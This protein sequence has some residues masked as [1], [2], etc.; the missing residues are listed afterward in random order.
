MTIIEEGCALPEQPALAPDGTE[1][2]YVL[3]TTDR[4]ADQDVRA[5]WRVSGGKARQLT[6]GKS[7][8]APAWSPGGS[9]LAFLRSTEDRPQIWLLDGGEPEQVTSLPHGAGQPVWSPD[10]TKLAFSAPVDIADAQAPIVTERLDH[11]A[12]G[13]G[14]LRGIRAHLHVLDLETREVEQ[15]TDGDWFAGTPA[16]SPDGTRL[17]FTGA[18]DDNA[19]LTFRVPVHVVEAT[20]HAEPKLAGLA[21]G[22]ATTVTWTAEGL[23]VTGRTTADV[24]HLSV[25]LVSLDGEVRDLSKALDRNV[26]PGMA[27][28]P[29]GPP[30]LTDGTI[31]FCARD[32]GCTQ[33]YATKDDET[34]LLVGGDAQV[35]SGLS[36]A[37][38]KAA[39]VLSTAT[40]FGEVAT[41]DLATGELTVHTE[42]GKA[43]LFVREEREFSIS[44]GTVVHGWLVRD[45]A[46]TGPQP[47]LLDIHGGPHNAWNGAADP[48]HRYHQVL[49]REGWT[50]LLLNPRG[51]DGYGEAFYTAALGAWGKADAKDLLEPIDQLVAEE[52]ADPDKLAVT[53]YSYGGYLTCYL[54]SRDTRFAAAVAGGV[55]SDLNSMAGTSDG[56]HYLTELEL[57]GTGEHVAELSP[58]TLADQVRTPTLIYHGTADDRCPVGQ[59]EQWFTTLRQNGVPSKLVLYPDES[60]LFIF[61]GKPSHREDY[62]RRVVDWVREHVE[63]RR[64]LDAKHWQRRL[65]VLAEKHGVPG[66]ALGVLHHG[67]I[68]QAHHGVLNKSTGV[69][70]TDDSV[71]QIGSISKVWTTTL[72]MQLVDEGL[73]DLDAP[74]ID[75]LPE[76][77]LADPVAEQKVTM[78]HLLTHTSGIDGDIFTDTGR[79]DDCLERYTELLAQAR[80]N[81]PLGATFSYCNSGFSLAGRVIEKL[82]GQTWDAALRERLCA[83]LALTHTGTLPEEA[84]M[85]RAAVG[86]ITRD[87]K[88]EPAPVWTLARS[89]GPA[90]TIFAT[91]ADLLTFAR[92]HLDGVLAQDG[93]RVLSEASAKAMTEKQ[94]DVP[95]PEA[96]GDSWGLGWIRFGWDGQRLI[97]HDGN[98]IGQSAFLRLLPEQNLAVTLLTNGGLPRELYLALFREIF[99]E[100]AGLDM[101]LPR[102]PAAEPPVVDVTRHVGRYE[103]ASVILDVTEGEHGLQLDV[104]ST[105]SLADMF[106]KL[107][108]VDLVPVDDSV[109]LYRWPDATSWSSL[110]FYPLPTGEQYLHMALRAT[111]KVS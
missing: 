64:P 62:N 90:G 79:G 45:P 106:P 66:A 42:H 46:R 108:V 32:R 30:S 18:R 20:R 43:D 109:F 95:D 47:L 78:R 98:T 7:D 44:D 55:V 56:G 111:P 107:P 10:G 69:E 84:L 54:T 2:V 63:N 41:V 71:F 12:D 100:L 1:I 53:G 6:R 83:P 59:A 4:E 28:Y 61:S 70:V 37:S 97:G 88:T 110:V 5:L 96:L 27:G 58:L 13:S 86:H 29:G 101:P 92:M 76:L 22:Q 99:A 81:H 51:S 60:H 77:R 49:A 24:G 35:V 65:S 11:K 19:D 26:M 57:G 16:W 38:G 3:R 9:R 73:L 80:Q 40:S 8:Q 75:V 31:L 91:T 104:T 33:L 93:T 67:E 87:D 34:R 50:I 39:I 21:E 48:V 89:A 25:L 15:I 17:A 85:F 94:T 102:E 14:Y 68:V 36:V 72:V 82:T 103:R 74:I 23:L 105:S 52:L